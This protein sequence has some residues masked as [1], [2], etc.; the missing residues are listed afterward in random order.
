[1][2]L[3]MHYVGEKGC[4]LGYFQQ[5]ISGLRIGVDRSLPFSNSRAL[6]VF[7]SFQ[8]NI[9]KVAGA[10]PLAIPLQMRAQV[11]TAASSVQDQSMCLALHW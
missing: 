9:A 1:V 6:C 2:H 5:T 8:P 3:C 10:P 7:V 4:P 11:H